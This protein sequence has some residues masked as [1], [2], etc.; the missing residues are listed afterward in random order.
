MARSSLKTSGSWTAWLGMNPYNGSDVDNVAAIGVT[1]EEEANPKAFIAC[2]QE[3]GTDTSGWTVKQLAT[4][5][6][7]DNVVAG[8]GVDLS[9]YV[10]KTELNSTLSSYATQSWVTGRGYL[11]SSSLSGYATQSWVQSQGY[12][13]TAYTLP[14]ASTSTLGGIKVGAGLSISAAGVLSATGGGVADSVAWENVTGK[15]AFATVATSGSYNDLKDKPSIPSAYTLP[16]AS[17]DTLGGIKV[18]GGLTINGAGVL[19]ATGG[20]VADSVDIE[21]VAGLNSSWLALLQAAPT[22]YVTTDPTWAQVSGKPTFATVATSGSYD[23]LTDKPTIP[24]LSGYATQSWVNSQGFLTSV[25]W[26]DIESKPS[27]F[28]PSTH[29]HPV[30]QVTGIGTITF[31]GA[32]S[33]TYNGTQNISVNIPTAG[34][35]VADSVDW[36]NVTNKPEWI[37]TTKPAYTWAEIGG[38]PSSFTPSTHT[39]SAADITSGVLAIDRIPTGISAST[40]ALGNHT[41]SQYLT[42][43]SL[44]GYATQSWVQQQGYLTSIP[45]NYVTDSELTATLGNYHYE[46]YSNPHFLN[47]IHLYTSQSGTIGGWAKGIYWCNRYNTGYDTAC[48]VGGMEILGDG[49]SI[50]RVS[51]GVAEPGENLYNIIN[52]LR[53]T[54]T[55]A[56]WNSYTL[57][58]WGSSDATS[59]HLYTRTMSVNGTSYSTFVGTSNTTLPTI[60]APT[61]VGTNKYVLQSNGSGAPSWVNPINLIV[62]K[63][64]RTD[65]ITDPETDDDYEVRILTQSE[66]N[67]LSTKSN[68][69]I[70]L[71]TD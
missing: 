58:T 38:K 41:H 8:G 3:D 53:I 57:A 25:A 16:I 22:R 2:A 54:K 47:N 33:A 6:Y 64:V 71:V 31:T 67:A 61:T 12:I 42:S 19:S 44:N 29:T 48:D 17:T 34:G 56:T 4:T 51:I 45:S 43:A 62:G 60:Y 20:G 13:T 14:T 21:N 66:Y 49:D 1:M 50:S 10:T 28:T 39:H 18:G 9:N 23:D 37:G 5:E 11:T 7:V 52:T 26:D 32:V 35:G 55:N 59:N 27:S 46:Y 40:V 68:Y 65:S 30:S 36:S 70:Y 63:S 15:P 69:T 24:S